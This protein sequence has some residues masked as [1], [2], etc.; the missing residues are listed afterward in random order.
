MHFAAVPG[1]R[2][3]AHLIIREQR[4]PARRPS[5][6]DAG[7]RAGFAFPG[8]LTRTPGGRVPP[9]RPCRSSR[10]ETYL[11]DA[12]GDRPFRQ[13]K[14]TVSVRQAAFYAFSTY[15][16]RNLSEVFYF[17]REYARI[18]AVYKSHQGREWSAYLLEESA[19]GY[20]WWATARLAI[21]WQ[22]S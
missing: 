8:V 11:P 19:C 18:C 12:C 22:S 2:R 20:W 1:K 6:R 4:K 16:K 13:R 10:P 15:S 5:L 3:S 17:S 7:L 14:G 21:R 9:P